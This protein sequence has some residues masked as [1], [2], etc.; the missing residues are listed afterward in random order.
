MK[1][2]AEKHY[3][4][5]W[6]TAQASLDSTCL[7]NGSFCK[8]VLN[9]GPVD[10]DSNSGS[11]RQNT[12]L[13]MFLLE[14]NSPR[15]Q[16]S[17]GSEKPSNSINVHVWLEEHPQN[18]CF[19]WD[20]HKLSH[21][22]FLPQFSCVIGPNMEGAWE[23]GEY[24]SQWL[25]SQCS[26]AEL[27][28]YVVLQAQFKPK[29]YIMHCS[30]T[31]PYS[32]RDYPQ[33]NKIMTTWN[34]RSSIQSPETICPC[35]CLL[36]HVAASVLQWYGILDTIVSRGENLGKV[37]S[38]NSQWYLSLCYRQWIV[39]EDKFG[40]TWSLPTEPFAYWFYHLSSLSHLV[41]M[42]WWYLCTCL[43]R[44]GQDMIQRGRL[45]YCCSQNWNTDL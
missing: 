11:A 30:T 9:F 18:G 43:G 27:Q 7:P 31:L 10:N 5:T 21:N 6:M 36:I 17:I 3:I 2:K 32:S 34:S 40:I 29:I 13:G 39:T 22:Y 41:V 33:R 4:C 42:R 14:A 16:V 8:F 25:Q 28:K 23:W 12:A 45:K 24:L 15:S 38:V 35:E 44:Q 19:K 26:T 20:C 37:D 1:I